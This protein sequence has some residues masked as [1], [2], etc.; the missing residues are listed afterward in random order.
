MRIGIIFYI[1]NGDENWTRVEKSW[2]LILSSTTYWLGDFGIMSWF[3]RAD[4]ALSVEW[5]IIIFAH[6]TD[7]FAYY[8]E[9]LQANTKIY[10]VYKRILHTIKHHKRPL[11]LLL[12]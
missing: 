7:L 9:L 10:K 4:G 2:E 5:G 12:L 8:T 3:G 6:H 11:E 1:D